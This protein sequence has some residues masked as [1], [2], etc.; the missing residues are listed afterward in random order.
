MYQWTVDML[1]ERQRAYKSMRDVQGGRVR[2]NAQMYKLFTQNIQAG[3]LVWYFDPR[4][5]PG[6]IHK[7]RLFWA[8]PYKALR[9]IA[10]EIGELRCV[11]AIARGRCDLAGSG[12]YRPRL[13]VR[14]R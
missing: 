4:I 5:I 14:Q 12:G 9:L 13:M 3:C 2:R 6:T 1:E 10:L 8:G 7:L 11:E